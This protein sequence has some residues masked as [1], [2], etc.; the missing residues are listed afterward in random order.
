MFISMRSTWCTTLDS[1]IAHLFD[2]FKTFLAIFGFFDTPPIYSQ[3]SAP[4][5]PTLCWVGFF[6]VLGGLTRSLLALEGWKFVGV[7]FKWFSFWGLRGFFRI[8]KKKF[9]FRKNF[10]KYK[11]WIIRVWSG[12]SNRSQIVQNLSIVLEIDRGT[13]F[14]VLFNVVIV[15]GKNSKKN[16]FSKIFLSTK[17]FLDLE[18][19]LKKIFFRFLVCFALDTPRPLLGSVGS[20]SDP[21]SKKKIFRT[22]FYKCLK[23]LKKKFFRFFGSRWLMTHPRLSWAAPRARGVKKSE[24]P[25]LF[26]FVPPLQWCPRARGTK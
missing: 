24:S 10:S 23:I 5:V 3:E 7:R 21:K 8:R 22:F 1:A 26:H 14:G 11:I 15:S 20:T 2:A 16:F 4:V 19:F 13:F 17:N 9:F 25:F 18:K 12:A 6:T